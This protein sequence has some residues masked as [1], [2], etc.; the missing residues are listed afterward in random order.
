MHTNL[1]EVI[2]FG[3][4]VGLQFLRLEIFLTMFPKHYLTTIVRLTNIE[5]AKIPVVQEP[6]TIGELLKFFGIILLII[7]TAG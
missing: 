2:T 6:I 5:L 1:G 4:N 3:S 7:E